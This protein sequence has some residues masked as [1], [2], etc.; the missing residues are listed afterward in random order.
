MSMQV[1]LEDMAG[2]LAPQDATA[3][4]TKQLSQNDSDGVQ[5]QG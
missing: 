5:V 1:S 4:L 3:R 2:T